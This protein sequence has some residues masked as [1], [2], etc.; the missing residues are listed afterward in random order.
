M[1]HERSMQERE[2]REPRES[3]NRAIARARAR[4]R[5]GRCSSDVSVA[6]LPGRASRARGVAPAGAV[7][8]SCEATWEVVGEA[9]VPVSGLSPRRG[10]VAHYMSFE[11]RTTRRVCRVHS[12]IVFSCVA[13]V[14]CAWGVTHPTHGTHGFPEDPRGDTP[15]TRD[16]LLPRRPQ[17]RHTASWTTPRHLGHTASQT[18]PGPTRRLSDNPRDT[19]DTWDTWPHGRGVT[20]S[21][22]WLPTLTGCGAHE[23]RGF[24]PSAWGRLGRHV[25][26]PWVVWEVICPMCRVCQ[27]RAAVCPMCRVCQSREAM[28]PICRVCLAREATCPMCRVCRA[29]EATCPMCRVC[30]AREAMCPMCRVCQARDAMCPMCRVCQGG[31]PQAMCPMCRVCQSREAMCPMCRVCQAREAMCPMCRV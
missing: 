21:N 20:H 5:S 2:E 7:N 28:C 9:M 4:E 31:A 10:C 25:L 18:T 30:Q 27:A 15:G 26:P 11:I 24:L 12:W 29:R 14:G 17:G 3:A 13:G 6:S 1:R 8:E 19:R 16:A 22:T 23:T